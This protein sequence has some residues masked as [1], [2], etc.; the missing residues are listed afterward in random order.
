M[1]NPQLYGVLAIIWLLFGAYE[2]HSTLASPNAGKRI[3]AAIADFRWQYGPIGEVC[4]YIAA[5]CT[6]ILIIAMGPILLI[7]EKFFK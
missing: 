5:I 6:V 4:W 1:F 2:L 3:K 7:K